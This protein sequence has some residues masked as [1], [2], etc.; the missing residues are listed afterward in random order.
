MPG[1][2]AETQQKITAPARLKIFCSDCP[3]SDG[4]CSEKQWQHKDLNAPFFDQP[5]S[6][7]YQDGAGSIHSPLNA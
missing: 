7:R 3:K 6:Y 2:A 5:L 1:Q 4:V